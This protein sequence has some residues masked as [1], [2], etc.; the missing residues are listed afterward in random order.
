MFI[1]GLSKCPSKKEKKLNFEG[2]ELINMSHNILS[3]D[4]EKGEKL[5][6]LEKICI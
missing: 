1:L 2:L 5:Y 6:H 3:L 4:N